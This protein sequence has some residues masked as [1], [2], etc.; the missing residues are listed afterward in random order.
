MKKIKLV[1]VVG[2][3]MLV[4]IAN[5]ADDA[6]PAGPY[7]VAIFNAK[8]EEVMS[9]KLDTAGAEIVGYEVEVST[10]FAMSPQ[11][12]GPIVKVTGGRT[13]TMDGKP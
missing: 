3:L 8:G 1:A 2:I 10:Q 9:A 12:P 6:V 5:A 4:G 13:L 7:R 11:Q